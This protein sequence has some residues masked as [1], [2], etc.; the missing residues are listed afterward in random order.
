MPNP[1]SQFGRKPSVHGQPRVTA[2]ARR[3]PSSPAANPFMWLDFTD[4]STLFQ[5]VA[6]T[7]PVVNGSTI[8]RI[9]N[10][11]FNPQNPADATATMQYIENVIAGFSVA[12]GT[13]PTTVQFDDPLIVNGIGPPGI[14]LA[15]VGRIFTPGFEGLV[16][17]GGGAPGGETTFRNIVSDWSFRIGLPIVNINNIKPVVVGEWNI[18]LI[19]YGPN[20]IHW[21]LSGTPGSGGPV[22]SPF[23]GLGPA[24]FLRLLEADS[25]LTE[26]IWWDEELSNANRANQL[27][28]FT[29][30]YG[31]FPQ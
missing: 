22:G 24:G 18:A 1:F 11:G 30:K 5:D 7:I 23:T 9:D 26:I 17:W 28:Y 2:G 25:E 31:A 6:G 20:G 29:G 27:G 21:D 10:K 8:R 12:K 19:S 15:A 16:R 14:T 13:A 3:F 4:P